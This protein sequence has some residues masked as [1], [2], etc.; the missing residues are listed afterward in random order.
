MAIYFGA[1]WQRI[2][3]EEKYDLRVSGSAAYLAPGAAS[4]T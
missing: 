2:L 4:F 1:D 3:K